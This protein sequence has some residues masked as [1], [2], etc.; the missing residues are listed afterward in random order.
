[1]RSSEPHETPSAHSRASLRAFSLL[2]PPGPRRRTPQS[3]KGKSKGDSAQARP[4]APPPCSGLFGLRRELTRAS[5][6]APAGRLPGCRHGHR[7]GALL[8]RGRRGAQV[9]G[10]G[11]PGRVRAPP[12]ERAAPSRSAARTAPPRSEPKPAPRPRDTRAGPS[13]ASRS[14]RRRG[15]SSAAARRASER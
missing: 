14:R 3:G 6:L 2:T 7:V 1:M 5:P 13:R 10:R 15:P 8:G 11:L 9:A 4:A 12:R